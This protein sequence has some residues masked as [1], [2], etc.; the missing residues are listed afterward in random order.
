ML[1]E[2]V[3][4][5]SNTMCSSMQL[6]QVKRRILFVEDAPEVAELMRRHLTEIADEVII[7]GNGEAALSLGRTQRFDL[8]ILDLIL[9]GMGGLDVCRSL[10]SSGFASPIIIV[11]AK[12]SELD[13]ILGLELGADD[14]LVKP[15]SVIE[16]VARVKASLRRAEIDARPQPAGEEKPIQLGQFTVDPASR[17]LLRGGE[18]VPLT[19]K[20][21]DLLLLLAQNPGRAFSRSRLVEL[22]WGQDGG[23]REHTVNS[24]INRLRAKIEADPTNPTVIETVWGVGYRLKRDTG[25]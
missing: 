18:P 14:Y 13:R 4:L 23:T 17:Q 2:G 10:R 19:A 15:F 16:L 24:H 12:S 7:V 3:G 11:T 25:N 8:I 9:P 20:E 22:L 1:T 21:F 6:A 5:R